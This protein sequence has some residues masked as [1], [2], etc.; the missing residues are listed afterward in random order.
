M[1]EK[2][3]RPSEIFPISVDSRQRQIL[4]CLRFGEWRS[5]HRLPVPIGVKSLEKLI[6]RG[7]V[8]VRGDT[9]SQ[10]IRITENGLAAL[11]S[12]S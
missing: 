8:E 11:I 1:A 2:D 4:D 6:L 9:S 7:W 12:P 5:V 10:E 3:L